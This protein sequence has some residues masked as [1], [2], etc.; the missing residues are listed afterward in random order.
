MITVFDPATYTGGAGEK[1]VIDGVP[2]LEI[3]PA[4][5]WSTW[6]HIPEE[7]DLSGKTTIKCIVFGEEENPN[8][9]AIV[10]LFAEDD[11]G[12]WND[13]TKI[14]RLDL[15]PITT[16]PTEVQAEVGEAKKVAVIQLAV[17]STADWSTLSDV[18]IRIGKITA[19]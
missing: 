10:Q 18:T 8:A 4:D 6:F 12:I 5:D 14:C 17:Q 3:T 13:S 1:V 16:A 15:K 7:V 11:E 19:E 9:Q 2:Y